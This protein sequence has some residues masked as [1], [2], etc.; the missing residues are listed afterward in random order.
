MARM[1][2]GGRAKAD[3]RDGGRKGRAAKP[4]VP[5]DVYVTLLFVSMG[6]FLMAGVFLALELNQYG[7]VLS[8]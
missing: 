8:R 1:F 5:P 7:W 4:D 6:A 3:V 2:G